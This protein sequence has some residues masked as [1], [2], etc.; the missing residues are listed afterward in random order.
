MV[1]PA[2]RRWLSGTVILLLAGTIGCSSDRSN[3]TEAN[4]PVGA[5]QA[6]ISI[7]N[8]GPVNVARG[9]SNSTD[10]TVSNT[11]TASGTVSLVCI[12]AKV[13]CGLVTPNSGVIAPGQHL[14]AEVHWTAFPF[15][16]G[17][18]VKL[19]DNNSGAIGTQVITFH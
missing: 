15:G 16:G 7:N 9:S 6:L 12:G 14:V 8:P 2:T 1:H 5:A 11:G 13:T 4:V 10:F 18:T 19:K 3:L 17:G